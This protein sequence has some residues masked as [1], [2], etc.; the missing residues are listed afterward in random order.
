VPDN[1]SFALNAFTWN[2]VFGVM[3][4][5]FMIGLS[6]VAVLLRRFAGRHAWKWCAVVCLVLGVAS[7]LILGHVKL[8]VD[9]A[10][11]MSSQQSLFAVGALLQPLLAPYFVFFWFVLLA[12]LSPFHH[13][14]FT[15]CLAG[16]LST[17][18][19]KVAYYSDHCG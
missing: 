19:D 11:L 1:P 13:W 17:S 10:Q 18:R 14:R 16:D 7:A 12:L 5:V 2:I 4:L 15:S 6:I 8:L 3:V 9:S